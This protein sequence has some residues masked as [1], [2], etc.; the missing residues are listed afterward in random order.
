MTPA[1]ARFWKGRKVLLTGHTGFK[2]SWLSLWLHSLGAQV[3]GFSLPPRTEPNLFGQAGVAKK[4]RSELGD[5]RDYDQ[6]CAVYRSFEPEVVFHLAAQALVR[7][8]YANPIETFATNVMGTVHLLEAARQTPSASSVVIVTSDKCYENREWAW[9]Y[10][11]NEPMGGHDPYSSSKGCA[12]LV[13]SAFRRSYFADGRPSA[14]ASARAGNVVG[15]GDWSEDRLLPD[16]VRALQAG[17]SID[18]RNPG[19]TRP[20]QHVLEPLAGYLR[21]AQLA[22]EKPDAFSRGWNFG[23]AD[24]DARPVSWIAEKVVSLWGQGASWRTTAEPGAPRE[25]RALKLDCSL[26]RAELSWAP[27]LNLNEGLRWTVDWYR[28]FGNGE[29]AER[30]CHEQLEAYGK[31]S[32]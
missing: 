32:S 15:G 7:P 17:K 3:L 20:W 16:C 24:D 28:R 13:T 10:R 11:E 22:A 14:V 4:I 6:L 25:A 21:L 2:G 29:S 31:L 19:S 18:I 30:L 26:A 12:E 5:I 8:S 23:P 1:D 9:G 27:R